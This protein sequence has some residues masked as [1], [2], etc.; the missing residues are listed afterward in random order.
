MGGLSRAGAELLTFAAF[1]TVPPTVSTGKREFQRLGG[2]HPAEKFAFRLR[3]AWVR[4]QARVVRKVGLAEGAKSR[5][6]SAGF[7]AAGRSNDYSQ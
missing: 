5:V 2:S 6:S 3:Q 1:D 4:H 7:D